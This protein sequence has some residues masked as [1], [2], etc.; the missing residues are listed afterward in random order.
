MTTW[1]SFSMSTSIEFIGAVLDVNQVRAFLPEARR[2]TLAHIM[3]GLCS[4][5]TTTARQCLKLL[6]H[7]AA[8]TYMVQ[9]ARLRLRPLQVWLVSVYRPGRDS[10]DMVLTVQRHTLDS[11]CWWLDPHMVG[12]GV[13][14]YPPQPTLTLVTDASGLGWRAHLGSLMTPGLWQVEELALHINIEELRAICLACQAFLSHL[15]G[16]CVAVLT[17]NT[18]AMFYLNKQGGA[19]LS[20]LCQEALLPAGCSEM[21]DSL[22]RRF[23]IHKW[24]IRPDIIHSIFRS[25]GFL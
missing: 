8:C 13:P 9:H 19:R 4:F 24:S 7:M 5:S 6:G 23:L 22:S 15:Q 2:L 12:A 10:L 16:H 14:F 21:A 1:A 20:P 18:T 17:D 3:A 11:L 25:W